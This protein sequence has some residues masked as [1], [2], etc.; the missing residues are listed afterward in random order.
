[1]AGQYGA[2]K[3]TAGAGTGSE[4]GMGEG[5]H[6][7]GYEWQQAREQERTAKTQ[8]PPGYEV[9]TGQGGCPRLIGRAS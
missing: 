8:A 6:E 3:A 2:P 7:H 9:G 5:E 1:M 4:T